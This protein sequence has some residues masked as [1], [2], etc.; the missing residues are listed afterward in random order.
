MLRYFSWI[1]TKEW[2]CRSVAWSC[3]YLCCFSSCLFLL[4]QYVHLSFLF[5]IWLHWL[6]HSVQCSVGVFLILDKCHWQGW[7]C[8]LLVEA[9]LVSWYYSCF[10][11][12]GKHVH[13]QAEKGP[14]FFSILLSILFC[15]FIFVIVLLRKD[16]SMP[17][18]LDP[19]SWPQV[20][21][22]RDIS[23][24]VLVTSCATHFCHCSTL[25]WARSRGATEPHTELCLVYLSNKEH[26]PRTQTI[27][28]GVSFALGF[29][30]SWLGMVFC[31]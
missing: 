13:L 12:V 21:L 24:P 2:N 31:Q 19:D 6:G 28:L 11:D 9:C 17:P 16:L 22:K 18:S 25:L 3:V 5:L 30:L 20:I 1:N 8:S 27:S 14:C 26:T 23:L 15:N 10:T 7:G 4:A 29:T